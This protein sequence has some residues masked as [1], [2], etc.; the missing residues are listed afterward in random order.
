[1]RLAILLA[2]ALLLSAPALA[3]TD[4]YQWVGNTTTLYDGAGNGLGFV[5]MT[6]QCR[7]EFGAGARMCTSQEILESDTLNFNAFAPSGCWVRPIYQ[8][9]G[10][11]TGTVSTLDASGRGQNGGFGSNDGTMSCQGW[12]ATI[13]YGLSVNAA[14]GFEPALCS[15]T[16]AIACCS[17]TPVPG[18]TSSLPIGTLGIAVLASLRN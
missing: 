1:M 15:Q 3:Q 9:H 7:A 12:S 17:P 14:G 4:P 8:P 5:G 13:Q 2:P 18:P 6:S 10:N 16:R 11:G